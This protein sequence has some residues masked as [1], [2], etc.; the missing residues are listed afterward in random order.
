[1]IPIKDDNP[2]SSFPLFTVTIIVLNVIVFYFELKTGYTPLIERFGAVP[3]L[4]LQGEHLETLFTSMFL[5]GGVHAHY[6]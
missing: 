1:M 3:A 6:R 4:I 5:H 2:R